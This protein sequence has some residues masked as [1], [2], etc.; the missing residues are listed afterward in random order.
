MEEMLFDAAYIPHES[1]IGS[2]SRASGT[3]G[4][5][6]KMSHSCRRF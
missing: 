1:A 3:F 2:R 6:R 4:A 5:L